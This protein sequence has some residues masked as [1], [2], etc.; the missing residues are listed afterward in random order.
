MSSVVVT[1]ESV[2]ALVGALSLVVA[3]VGTL[4]LR[5]L[6]QAKDIQAAWRLLHAHDVALNGHAKPPEKAG[7]Q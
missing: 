7:E 6:Q 4:A 3:A 5:V 2:L 1:P